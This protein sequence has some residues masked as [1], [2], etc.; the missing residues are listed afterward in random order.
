MLLYPTKEVNGYKI[1]RGRAIPFGSSYVDNGVNF[2]IASTKAKS[3]TLVLFYDGELEPFVEI[4]FPEEFKVGNVFTM[5]LFDLDFSNIEYGYRLDGEFKPESGDRFDKNRVLLDPYAKI[6]TGINKWTRA[7]D[8]NRKYPY[9]AKVLKDSF[10]WEGDK[11]L[12]TPIED[13]VIYEMHIRGFTRDPSSKVKSAGTFEGI[14]EKIPYLKELGVN[15]LEFMPIFEFDE[16]EFVRVNPNSQQVLLNYWGYSTV[17]FFAPK[18]GYAKSG[19]KSEQVDELKSLIKELHKNKIEVILDVVFNHTAEGNES[20][21]T[22]SFKGIDNSIY[23]MLTPDGK[24]FNFSGCGNTLNCNHPIVRNLVLDCLRYWVSE[25]HIDGFRFDLASILGRD[26]DGKPL[27]NPPLLESLANDP[28][29]ANSKLIA[30]A[31]DAGGLYQVGYFPAYGRFAEWN[32]KFRDTVRQFLRGDFGC[33]NDIALRVQGS[34]D[35]YH[36]R[37]PTASINFITSHDGFT[38][39]D[40]FSYNSKHNE[41]NGESNRDGANDNYSYNYGVEGY[42]TDSKINRVRIKQIK[43]ALTILMISQGIPMLLMGDEMGRVQNGNNNAY[44]HD[45][46]ISWLDWTLLQKNREIFEFTKNLIKFRFKHPAL[47]GKTHFRKSDYV[48]S[49]FSDISLHGTEPFRCDLSGGSR[50]FAFMLCGEHARAGLESDNYIYVAMNMHTEELNFNFP[51]VKGISWYL[52]IDTS[53]KLKNDFFQ[54]E[55]LL[56]NQKGIVIPER[57]IIVL[58]G[59]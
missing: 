25:Y 31:W 45:N 12:N 37:G 13:I 21:P 43:N 40:M 28:I 57:S 42:T 50:V 23:Y 35:L 49:G 10:D 39:M 46:R 2:S 7:I 30:E 18:A 11:Q 19:V 20:G 53:M 14:K 32:G 6:I 36:Q 44:C 38:L 33:V 47:R 5:V 22:I 26:T 27:A 54:K 9:R 4:E 55:R 16:L 15:A 41:A 24:Y 8:I 3:C 58:I 48:G 56:S 29:L 51:E 1:G 52:A 17:G 59:K 34:P